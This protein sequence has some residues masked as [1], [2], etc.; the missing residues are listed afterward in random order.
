[1]AA[2]RKQKAIETIFDKSLPSKA[3]PEVN[4]G[5][6]AFL[7]SEIVQY[8]Q[9]RVSSLSQLHEKL[10]DLGRHVGFRMIDLLCWRDKTQKERD[11]YW[12]ILWFIQKTVWKTLFGK[13]ADRLEQA[14]TN[15]ATY[16]LFE[17]E[18]LVNRFISVP[19]EQSNLNCAAFMAGVVEAFLCGVQFEEE[20][21]PPLQQPILLPRTILD[22]IEMDLK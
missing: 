3:K 10:A 14:T 15:E 1:M 11:S 17:D 19:K 2:V 13:E 20:V 22:D 5:T 7:F 18:P 12:H 16:Y 6:F 21:I 4:L 8:N 9:Q